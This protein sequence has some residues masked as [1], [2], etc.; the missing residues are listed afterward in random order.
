MNI[1]KIE[2][3]FFLFLSEN[4]VEFPQDQQKLPFYLIANERTK[5]E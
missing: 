3:Q 4:E 2:S 1:I 5:G